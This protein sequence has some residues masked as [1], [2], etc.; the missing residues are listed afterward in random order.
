MEVVEPHVLKHKQ[1]LVQQNPG[2]GDTWVA[3]KHMKEFNNWFK[4][5]VIVS[6]VENDDI[7][8]LAAGPIFTVMTYR[9][10]DINDY[11][12]YTVH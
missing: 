5:H 10:Y 2:R 4:D 8:K 3:K 7:K 11:T 6:N 1:L 9:A 12:I